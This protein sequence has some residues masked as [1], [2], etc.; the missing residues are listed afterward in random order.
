VGVTLSTANGE[1][2]VGTG[3]TGGY[4]AHIELLG[5]VAPGLSC[6]LIQAGMRALEV[7]PG[8]FKIVPAEVAACSAPYD[9]APG[10]TTRADI[11]VDQRLIWGSIKFKDRQGSEVPMVEQGRETE[12]DLAT[13]QLKQISVEDADTTEVYFSRP[14]GTSLGQYTLTAAGDPNTNA[15]ARAYGR[16]ILGPATG[17]GRK[18]G[19]ERLKQGDLIQ[20]FAIN[21]A[22]GYAGL[23]TVTVPPLAQA[24]GLDAS[25]RCAADDTAGGPL[26]LRL[27]GVSTT[28]SRCAQTQLGLKADVD[29]YPPE[30]DVRVTRAAKEDGVQR[31]G[32]NLEHLVRHGGAATTTDDYLAISTHWR[33]RLA[34]APDAGVPD[35]GAM[36]AGG[37]AGAGPLR[38]EGEPGTPLEVLCSEVPPG[39]DPTGCMKD[40][41]VLTDVP[42]GIPV[43]TSNSI[44]A[45]KSASWQ[46]W[47]WLSARSNGANEVGLTGRGEL[48]GRI[49]VRGTRE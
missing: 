44:A 12:F 31:A 37:D 28:L 36:D 23:K 9:V 3:A 5:G 20:V 46:G 15:N 27:A 21:H 26:A 19:Y 29:L 33:V 16:L 48:E 10:H 18:H 8:V 41:A 40:D 2:L 35:G 34:T 7:T 1:K 30:I 22:T 17:L 47:C 39:G 38:E 6:T 45:S 11:L 14:D 25:G 13:W 24:E 32:A 49:I 42:G 43:P 4:S